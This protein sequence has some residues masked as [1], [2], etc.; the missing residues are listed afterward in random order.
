VNAIELGIDRT[1]VTRWTPDDT[2]PAL[3]DE[4][5]IADE[6]SADDD[7]GRP[8]LQRVGA[9]GAAA[10]HD[11]TVRTDVDV[12][13]ALADTVAPIPDDADI[14][15]L[16]RRPVRARAAVDGHPLHPVLVPLPIGAFA[17][18]LIADLAYLRTHDRFWARGARLL[19]TAG[20]ATG[21]L[22][23]SLGAI[24]FTGRR[25]I[26][27]HRAAWVHGAGNLGVMA[28]A[29][30]S[31]ALRSRDERRAVTDGGVVISA[32]IATVLLVTGWLGGELAYRDQ[33]GVIAH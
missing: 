31:L 23:G 25:Q 3:L 18:A 24:D 13:S 7:V 26:R 10:D 1:V 21:A 4:Y 8:G 20:L 17:G 29:L 14:A 22:A 19:T 30:G 6:S 28:L 15:N 12:P 33:I 9:G 2:W 5:A 32:T 11:A 16:V 27:R